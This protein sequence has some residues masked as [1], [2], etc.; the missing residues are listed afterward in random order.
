MCVVILTGRSPAVQ[1]TS[2]VTEWLLN[3]ILHDQSF[4]HIFRPFSLHSVDRKAKSRVLESRI[5]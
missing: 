2:T 3:C 5:L 4:S 1:S